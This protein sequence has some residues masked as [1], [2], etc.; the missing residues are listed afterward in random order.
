MIQEAARHLQDMF[1]KV[2]ASDTK[3]RDMMSDLHYHN[4][5]I[6]R[7]FIVENL[8]NSYLTEWLKVNKARTLSAKKAF[9]RKNREKIKNACKDVYKD[10]YTKL[11][12]VNNYKHSSVKGFEL[13]QAGNG[14]HIK[15]PPGYFTARRHTSSPLG[16]GNFSYLHRMFAILHQ[17]AAKALLKELKSTITSLSHR[18]QM[19]HG[20]VGQGGK[21]TSYTE[22]KLHTVAKYGFAAE[23]AGFDQAGDDIPGQD[24]EFERVNDTALQNAGRK[25]GKQAYD[26]IIERYDNAIERKFH[27]KQL[28]NTALN[29]VNTTHEVELEYSNARHN[30]LMGTQDKK[31][32]QNYVKHMEKLLTRPKELKKLAKQYKT[33]VKDMK[34]SSS[35]GKR[36]NS[37]T[38][39]M[40]VQGLLPTA[41]PDMRVNKRLVNLA[42]KELGRNKGKTSLA[43]PKGRRRGKKV[44]AT[45]AVTKMK[46]PS[47]GGMR[48]GGAANN[49]MALKALLNEVLPSQVALNMQSPALQFRT[50]RFANNVRVENVTQGPRG[51]NTMIEASYQNDPYETFARGGKMYTPQRDPD[52]LI[53]KSVRQVAMGILGGRFGVNVL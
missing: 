43:G 21:P 14:W 52:K 25:V 5:Y 30:R 53:R 15:V 36:I 47:G 34:G 17:K 19:T 38:P 29:E 9:I 32:L 10:T 16:L 24:L 12:I 11:N 22:S 26:H 31:G 45:A 4:I 51:G 6:K 49:P 3:Y 20:M 44:V 48:T 37:V 39:H 18:G 41:T 1:D 8:M 27:L 46:K 28:R 42:K 13:N 50:G 7:R 35:F 2:T 33:T 40:L 23:A